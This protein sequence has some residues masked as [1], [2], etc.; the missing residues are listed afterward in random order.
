MT[1][2]LAKRTFRDE[3]FHGFAHAGE[4]DALL[5]ELVHS[6]FYPAVAGDSVV[7]CF[8]LVVDVVGQC[9]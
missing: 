6:P 2:L 5:R 1:H 4:F 9:R 7:D 8:D 3:L